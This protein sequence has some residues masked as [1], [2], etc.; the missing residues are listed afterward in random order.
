MLLLS[1]IST[2]QLRADD[3]SAGGTAGQG[4][5]QFNRDVRPLLAR[6]CFACHG[7]DTADQESDLRLDSFEA[8]TQQH[9]GTAAIVPGDPGRSE[10]LAR[11][12][13]N[14]SDLRMPPAPQHPPLTAREVQLLRD[15]IAGGAKYE[16]HWA[17]VPPVRP[18][19]P[20]LGDQ[21][22]AV[23]TIDHFIRSQ[24]PKHGLVAS[25]AADARTLARR[26]SLDLIGL[27]P[28]PDE[29][30]SFL[31]QVE[32]EG[33]ETA[34]E[35]L[36]DRLLASPEYGVRW[37]RKWLDLARYADTNGYEKDRERSI[38]PYR[39]WVVDALN[40]DLPFDQFTIEQIAGDLLAE[41]SIDQLV[42][43]GFHRNTMLNEEGGIDPLEFR[44]YAMN[45]RVA[46]TGTTW[47]GL[48]LFCCQCHSHKYD[49]VSQTEYYQL[50]ALLNNTDEIDLDL[51][52]ESTQQREEANRI[53]AEE[54]LAGLAQQWPAPIPH[55]A[56]IWEGDAT[57]SIPDSKV[58]IERRFTEWLTVGRAQTIQWQ[59]LLPQQA[60]S[61]LPLLTI[62]PDRS[63]LAS[64]DTTKQ[65]TYEVVF[66]GAKQ[67]IAALRLEALPDDSLPAHGPGTTFYEGT[68]GDFFLGEFE[69]FAD[70]QPVRFVRAT[71]SYSKNRFGSNPVN[72]ALT[73]DGDPQTGWS[74]H[75]RQGERHTA[76]FIPDQPIPAAAELRLK[77][78]FG[79]H[80]SSSLGRFRLQATSEDWGP[81]AQ[82]VTAEVEALL[83]VP[84]ALLTPDQRQRLSQEFLL[85]V[86][87]LSGP[88]AEVR[89]LREPLALPTSLVFRERP[90]ENPRPTHF[91]E[92]GEYL[93][94][95]AQ[96][97]PAT[98][99]VL[100]DWPADQPRTR[101][102]LA[103][104]LVS[105]ENPLTARVV[106][107][108]HWAALF[109]RGLVET[110]DDLGT[111]GAPPSHPELLDW[112][113]ME[114]MEQGWSLKRL[115]RL[116][117]LSATY[118]QSSAVDQTTLELDPQNVWLARA[119]RPRLEAEVLR[120][121]ILRAAGLL[122][123][124]KGGPGVRPPQP[125]GVTEAAY[126]SPHWSASQ[127]PDR[128]RRSL[129]TFMKRTAPFAMYTTFDAPTGESCVA[130][131]ER[132]NTPLQ[133]LTLLN[134]QMFLE[135]AQALGRQLAVT[136]GSDDDKLQSAFER[137]LS[138]SPDSLEQARLSEFIATQ[139][140]RLAAG[141]LDANAISG[142]DADENSEAA[143]WTILARVLFGLDELATRN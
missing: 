80:Y 133:A 126:G 76:V 117:V 13:T 27:P 43:T 63:V 132:S 55:P 99:A 82:D 60:S 12:T 91:H 45:D 48:T 143:A 131:R 105:R 18:A 22:G 46:T 3:D 89:R 9:G 127:G 114:F 100:H 54:L 17:F 35:S 119:A 135:A 59:S 130:R 16:Q 65:D 112:L 31:E 140:R 95:A 68:K 61:N 70:G 15:W 11:I 104:W 85:Q 121:S 57:P 39:D 93:R 58:L 137:V 29:L 50:M 77:M 75:G 128:Y 115:H 64:G 2:S 94:P 120:D 110:V 87:E 136:A 139:R 123:Y 113:A 33:L 10:L 8:A 40:R 67:E 51:P 138:R 108:R 97:A 122:S 134:D 14:D 30:E 88:A 66:E 19:V 92:R 25:P 7:P 84:E 53:R 34:Y 102:G 116:M 52:D 98:P 42:A 1:V 73:L 71:E 124:T 96:V 86:A 6:R 4:A 106:V 28:T 141:E 47:L 21:S 37:A 62:L 24:L 69:L 90:P 109:G 79:R 74:V 81:A 5:V 72:A 56:G 142:N 49:P 44:F 129:Y 83:L 107:N 38:W 36:V 23:N 118:R 103:R 26:V 20:D 111:Q 32:R 78:Q 41:P 125:D 101:L